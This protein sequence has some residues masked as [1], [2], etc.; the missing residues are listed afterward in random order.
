LLAFGA[1]AR[2]ERPNLSDHCV[3]AGGGCSNLPAIGQ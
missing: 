2:V 3:L 1:A